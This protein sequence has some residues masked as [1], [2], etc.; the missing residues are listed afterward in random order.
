MNPTEIVFW[1]TTIIIVGY[2]L[3]KLLS[4]FVAAKTYDSRKELNDLLHKE[5]YKVKGRFE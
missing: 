1:G 2:I 4:K 5:E 3:K